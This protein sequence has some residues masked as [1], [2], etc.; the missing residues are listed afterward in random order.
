MLLSSL[1][2]HNTSMQA[3]DIRISGT[4]SR[5]GNCVSWIIEHHMSQLLISY[6]VLAYEPHYT[7][8]DRYLTFML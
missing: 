5:A 6:R 2:L 3:D 1:H 7:K 8:M 4:L